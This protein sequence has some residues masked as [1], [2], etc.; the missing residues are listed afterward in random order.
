MLSE[1]RI[2]GDVA[3]GPGEPDHPEKKPCLAHD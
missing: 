3:T 2:H 1:R